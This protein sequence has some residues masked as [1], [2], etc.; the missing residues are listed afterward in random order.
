MV[1]ASL[2]LSLFVQELSLR[3]VK[4][5]RNEDRNELDKD[6]MRKSESKNESERERI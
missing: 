6:R 4:R 5:I 3:D 2:S 1:F